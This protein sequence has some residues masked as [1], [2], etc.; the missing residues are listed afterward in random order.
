MLNDISL[1]NESWKQL[2]NFS[3]YFISNLGRIWSIRKEHLMS[4][5]KQNSG[6]LQNDLINDS[7]KS[8]RFLL[9]RL[10]ALVWIPNPNN[11]FYV[12]HID[13]NKINNS[14]SNL[15]WCTNSENILHARETGLNPYNLPTLNKKLGGL[16]KAKSKYFGVVWDNSRQKWKSAVVYKGKIYHQKRFDSE[17]EA[18]KY[19][20]QCV[21]LMGLQQIKTM[22]NI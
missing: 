12:N 11:K 3:K 18:A 21:I 2:P 1:P 6:Y 8:V 13:G 17:L 16:R 7:G 22:N 10:V 20:N 5:F 14:V 9:H 4:P 15:E 19:Y